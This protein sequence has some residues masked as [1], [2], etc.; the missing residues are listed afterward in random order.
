MWHPTT[1][2]RYQSHSRTSEVSVIA[3]SLRVAANES[4]MNGGNMQRRTQML[5]NRRHSEF[6]QMAT[7]E[8]A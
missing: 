4:Q 6:S 8:D 5:A 3:T 1:M 2:I 7:T